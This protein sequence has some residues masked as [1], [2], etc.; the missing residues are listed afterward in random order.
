MEKVTRKQRE[1]YTERLIDEN[2]KN[3]NKFSEEKSD[4]ALQIV[5]REMINIKRKHDN[6]NPVE[7][8]ARL[9]AEVSDS[10]AIFTILLNVAV[11]KLISMEEE[12][13][14]LR[15]TIDEYCKEG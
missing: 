14:T 4:L 7:F 9:L 2:F 8:A 6:L 1:E 13:K 10:T 12:N 3:I 11:E 5:E 15:N